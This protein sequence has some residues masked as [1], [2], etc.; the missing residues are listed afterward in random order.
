[1]LYQNKILALNPN[2]LSHHME[3]TSGNTVA[4]KVFS[5][6]AYEKSKYFSWET[7][8]LYPI[9]SYVSAT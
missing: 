8:Q 1:M 4:M 3:N 6:W 9:L 5:L 7:T 2:S